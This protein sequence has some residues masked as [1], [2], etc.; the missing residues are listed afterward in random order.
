MKIINFQ[1]K[2]ELIGDLKL[3]MG[4]IVAIDGDVGTGKTNLSYCIG[5]K[6]IKNVVNLD[7]F[8]IPKQDR[9]VDAIDFDRLKQSINILKTPV[10]EGICI[11]EVLEKL[12]ITD[13]VLIY[14]KEISE[15]TG[16]WSSAY[17]LDIT[18]EKDY[19]KQI[20]QHRGL[21][22]EIIKY[23]YKYRPFEKADYIYQIINQLK[24]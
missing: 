16:N 10:I 1:N 11:L 7:D 13:Y 24:L 12:E 20:Q 18:D 8:H 21:D 6:L 19:Q 5:C 22:I 3:K 14:C 17:R 2:Q 4:S 15:N 9:F 23:H